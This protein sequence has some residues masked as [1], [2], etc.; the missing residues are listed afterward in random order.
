MI[1]IIIIIKSTFMN[2]NVQLSE[3]HTLLF[4]PINYYN[5]SYC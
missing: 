5:V 1:I 4:Q 3:K 2:S